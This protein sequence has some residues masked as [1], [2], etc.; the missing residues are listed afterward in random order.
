MYGFI[1]KYNPSWVR[2]QLEELQA[3]RIWSRSS[4][5]LH[6]RREAELLLRPEAVAVAEELR[7]QVR[8]SLELEAVIRR[9][10]D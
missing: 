1:S 7:K 3:I 9:H 10:L 8:I 4:G 2:Q 5:I 6:M